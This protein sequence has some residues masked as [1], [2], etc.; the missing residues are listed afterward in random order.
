MGKPH[1][2]FKEAMSTLPKL[3]QK[4]ERKK[5]FQTHSMR[6]PTSHTEASK[7]GHYKKGTKQY[8]L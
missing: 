1:Q 7:E 4:T 6:P 3:F 2:T 5:H 8:S